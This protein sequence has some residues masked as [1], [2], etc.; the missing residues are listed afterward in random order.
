MR[1][2]APANWIRVQVWLRRTT[3]GHAPN[4]VRGRGKVSRRSAL[5]CA[6]VLSSFTVSL[7]REA[8]AQR[9]TMTVEVLRRTAVKANP[10]YASPT[11]GF[12]NPTLLAVTQVRVVDGFVQLPLRQID[13]TWP[14]TGYGYIAAADVA[15]DSG[16]TSTVVARTDTV[17]R[18]RP[19][20][21]APNAPA[22]V[23]PTTPVTVVPA[24]A[25][26]AAPARRDTMS[27]MKVDTVFHPTTRGT[28]EL[29]VRPESPPPSPAATDSPDLHFLKKGPLAAVLQR[30]MS[31]RIGSTRDSIVVPAG[32]VAEFTSVPRALWS[33]LSPVGEHTLAAIVHDYLYWFQPCEREETDNLLMIAMRERGVADLQRGAVY[34]GV[35]LG[36]ADAW[37]ANRAARDRGDLRIVPTQVPPTAQESWSDYRARLGKADIRGTPG[38]MARQ[39]F[40]ELGKA[41]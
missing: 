23:A 7:A 35:R 40:C 24:R 16:T 26:T 9:E 19:A 20:A 14:A 36:S 34:A 1:R 13:R 6:L 8:R 3:A 18:A 22:T 12:L 11:L 37:S 38:R 41:R 27:V 31:Y 5:L 4:P 2:P 28:G 10:S 21:A 15:V 25:D 32:F 30:P 33:E 39:S 17:A 29:L